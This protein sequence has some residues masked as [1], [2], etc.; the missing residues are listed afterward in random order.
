MPES[1]FMKFNTEKTPYPSLY[2]YHSNYFNIGITLSNK[3]FDKTE[4]LIDKVKFFKEKDRF[5]LEK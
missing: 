4:E 3:L 5:F 2:G 1:E